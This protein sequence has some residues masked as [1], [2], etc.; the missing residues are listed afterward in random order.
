MIEESVFSVA[1]ADNEAQLERL[2][3]EIAKPGSSGSTG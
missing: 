3:Y 2:R 1:G